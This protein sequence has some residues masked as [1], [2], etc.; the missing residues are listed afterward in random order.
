[1]TP[2]ELMFSEDKLFVKAGN[3]TYFNVMDTHEDLIAKYYF[4]NLFQK[5]T[6]DDVKRMLTVEN[7]SNERGECTK[8]GLK[9]SH[10]SM[11]TFEDKL[12][13]GFRQ[14]FIKKELI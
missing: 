12:D 2:K 10:V 14:S 4:E 1:M 7:V 8:V 3:L 5:I 13:E 11:W 9:F 6:L